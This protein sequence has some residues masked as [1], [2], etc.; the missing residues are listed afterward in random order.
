MWTVT[1]WT[2]FSIFCECP[3]RLRQRAVHWVDYEIIQK[4][5]LHKS[6]SLSRIWLSPSTRHSTKIASH[7]DCYSHTPC[8]LI[9]SVHVCNKKNYCTCAGTYCNGVK[10]LL[11]LMEGG[12]CVLVQSTIAWLLEQTFLSVLVWYSNVLLDPDFVV[13]LGSLAHTHLGVHP[14]LYVEKHN[15]NYNI[16]IFFQPLQRLI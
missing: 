10:N 6:G 1:S 16:G 8:L 4:N 11:S 13:L 3:V 5:L 15:M 7:S 14:G 12:V 2:T 9:S